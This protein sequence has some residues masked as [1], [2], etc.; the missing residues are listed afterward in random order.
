VGIAVGDFDGD[1][2][3]DLAVANQ[4]DG[5]VSIFLGQGGGFFKTPTTVSAGSGPS[6]IV[7]GDFN[8]DGKVDLAVI[9]AGGTV[10]ILLGNGDGTFTAGTPL[11]AGSA[12]AAVAAGAF[13]ANGASDLVVANSGSDN[14]TTLISQTGPP[15]IATQPTSQTINTG[16]TVVFTV[17]AGGTVKSSLGFAGPSAMVSS[18]TTYQWQFNGVDLTDGGGISGSTGPQLVIQG[19]TAA[20]DGSYVCIVTSGGLFTPSAAA[21]LSVIT[22]SNPGLATSISSR[23][24]VGTGDN[25]LIG[26][27]YIVGSTSRTVLIQGLG[28]ALAPLGVS[29][30]LQHPE[31]SIHQ[32]QNGGDVT[33]YSNTGWST[34]TGAAEQQVLLNAAA[35]AFATPV[36]SAGSADS[37]LLLTLPPGG[38][39]AEVGGADGGTGV[40]LCAIYELP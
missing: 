16:G 35:S 18:S 11:V 4:D 27:F 23:A 22:S 3:Q 12:P 19:A 20:N 2:R 10:T 1:G 7:A 9:D 38:Y 5:T 40:A 29:G 26:G 31:L 28:P 21:S 6:G 33:L 32:S 17:G 30:A 36:L 39:S 13:N 37:E 14:L 34:N 15:V 8:G 24:F 25:I